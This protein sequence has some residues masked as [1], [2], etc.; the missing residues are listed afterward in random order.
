MY[1]C[2]AHNSGHGLT[3]DKGIDFSSECSPID[4]VSEIMKLC[5]YDVATYSKCICQLLN[6]RSF[7]L[8]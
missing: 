2:L 5:D 6:W 7:G 8:G 4:I 3:M 1:N